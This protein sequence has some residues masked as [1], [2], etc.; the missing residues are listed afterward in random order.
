MFAEHSLPND[1]AMLL[2]VFDCCGLVLILGCVIPCRHIFHRLLSPPIYGDWTV[3]HLYLKSVHFVTALPNEAGRVSPS[4]IDIAMA[5]HVSQFERS[6]P[7]FQPKTKDRRLSRLQDNLRNSAST[8][9]VFVR[10]MLLPVTNSATGKRAHP[11]IVVPAPILIG[12]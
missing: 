8:S 3:R 6:A 11:T 9:V 2:Q 5:N 12:C 10:R 1:I 7:F 4:A